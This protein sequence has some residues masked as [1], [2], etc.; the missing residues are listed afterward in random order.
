MGHGPVCGGFLQDGCDFLTAL[1]A[2]SPCVDRQSD[3]GDAS[4]FLKASLNVR[5]QKTMNHR[6][7]KDVLY[8]KRRQSAVKI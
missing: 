1:T 2:C 4:M 5:R 3:R 7:W 6:V 8:M